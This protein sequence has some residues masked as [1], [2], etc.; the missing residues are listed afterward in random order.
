MSTVAKRKRGDVIRPG[1]EPPGGLAHPGRLD[2]NRTLRSYPQSTGR[3]RPRRR[4]WPARLVATRVS[5][6]SKDRTPLAPFARCGPTVAAGP[7]RS[8]HRRLSHRRRAGRPAQER[9]VAGRA[10]RG[11]PCLGRTSSPR[12]GGPSGR[13]RGVLL[14][15]GA[16]AALGLLAESDATP[17][18]VGE[19]PHC[20]VEL[21]ESG[22]PMCPRCGGP[23]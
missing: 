10:R 22:P 11:G 6:R 3:G 5:G 21:P 4:T 16:G 7:A 19:C 23:Y 20:G 1:S 9:E 14:R 18:D 15:P 13:R 17:D 8:C 12:A 2:R